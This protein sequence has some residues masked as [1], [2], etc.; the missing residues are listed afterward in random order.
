MPTASEQ[1]ATRFLNQIDSLSVNPRAQ[2]AFLSTGSQLFKLGKENESIKEAIKVLFDGNSN[3]PVI[4]QESLDKYELLNDLETV[5]EEG[6]TPGVGFACA[7]LY[8]FA[9]SQLKDSETISQF[10]DVLKDSE[11]TLSAIQQ[12]SASLEED[13]GV[14]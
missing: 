7:L 8:D 10:N 11:Q 13:I 5:I 14:K 3:S 1:H 12:F 4:S 6:E 9:L 2:S